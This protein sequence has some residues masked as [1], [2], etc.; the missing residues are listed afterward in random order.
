MNNV[1]SV[2]YYLELR[3]AIYI[4]IVHHIFYQQMSNRLLNVVNINN[5]TWYKKVHQ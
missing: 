1:F 5:F 3:N 2:N 4:Y